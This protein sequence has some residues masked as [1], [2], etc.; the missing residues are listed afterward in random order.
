MRQ[1]LG[2]RDAL[3]LLE[4]ADAYLRQARTTSDPVWQE[5]LLDLAQ[6]RQGLAKEA[7]HLQ[8]AQIGLLEDHHRR[9][10]LH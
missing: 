8:S 5:Q 6:A 1:L 7:Y 2:E 9:P 3:E 4:E 10:T